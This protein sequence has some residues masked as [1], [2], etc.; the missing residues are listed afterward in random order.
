MSR[1]SS[2][3]YG[4][5]ARRPGGGPVQGIGPAARRRRRRITALF[6]LFTL[7]VAV[8]AVAFGGW[9]LWRFASQ[10][11]VFNAPQKGAL[12]SFTVPEG[13][14]LAQIADILAE[15]NV[16]PRAGAFERRAERDGAAKRFQPGTFRLHEFEDYSVIV[17]TLTSV[18]L[19]P[20]KR[21]TIPE[22][23]TV[24]QTARRVGKTE[25]LSGAE[26]LEL[27]K[28]HP[29]EYRIS[30]RPRGSSLEGLLFPATYE[31]PPVK[32]T[33][34]LVEAQLGAFREH[35]AGVDLTR[36]KAHKLTPYDVVIIASLI[37]REVRAAEERPLVAAV[38]WNRLRKEMVL[39]IDASVAYGLG[40]PGKAPTI[41]DTR[42][43]TPYNTYL[44]PGLPPTPICSPGLA[45]LEAAAHP[46][47]VGYLYYVVRNDDSGRHYF[48]KT[49]EQFLKDKAKAG[50]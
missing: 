7:L 31:F 39:Q 10:G 8:G 2:R 37:E 42:I 1:R 41:K 3:R 43:D 13:A 18:A 50:L 49:Y 16:V 4:P 48:S 22:G 25:G 20:R 21:L 46:A 28:E 12:V 6:A 11:Y 36:A 27:T 19:R 47:D 34:G 9:A 24:E 40:K 14:S 45:S 5:Y 44:H 15:H 29:V 32:D 38:I 35:F 26:Y 17:K 30:G 33:R 23:F